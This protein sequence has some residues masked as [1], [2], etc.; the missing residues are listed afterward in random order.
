MVLGAAE[1]HAKTCRRVM[2]GCGGVYK[3]ISHS[4]RIRLSSLAFLHSMLRRVELDA[5]PILVILHLRRR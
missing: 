2:R 5:V 1:H 3:R 4:R